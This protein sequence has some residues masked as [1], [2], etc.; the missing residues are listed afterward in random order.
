LLQRATDTN[1]GEKIA[2]QIIHWVSGKGG[3]GKSTVAASLAL[4]LARSGRKTLL[5]ELGEKS[6]FRFLFG[7]GVEHVPKSVAPHLSVARWAGEECLRDYLLHF[8]KLERLVQ[9]FFD[10]RVTRSLIQA[11]PGLRELA[12]VG[13]I[14]GGIRGVGPSLPFDVLVVD[15]Y[16]TGH[17]RALVE[18]PK[19]MGDAIPVGPMG[20]QSRAMDA[21][22]KSAS[23]MRYH[24]VVTPEELP[25]TEGIELGQFITQKFG[26]APDVVI[27]RWL[28]PP[29]SR[30]EL[31]EL[32]VSEFSRY[33][34]FVMER[35]ASLEAEI[36]AKGFKIKRFP[37]AWEFSARERVDQLSRLWTFD[38]AH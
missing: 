22:L 17:F 16:A 25:V 21:V 37:Y 15:A 29:L 27:N 24:V 2:D 23:N 14:T 32:P 18:S 33:M 30:A 12:L 31:H 10:N 13:K 9:V 8:L 3:V 34:D 6:F 19:A 4:S 1:L 5:V 11:S 35:Q 28:D 20:E 26:V 38:N 36:A 7:T